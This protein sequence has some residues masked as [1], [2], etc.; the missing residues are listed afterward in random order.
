V[1]AVAGPRAPRLSSSARRKLVHGGFTALAL[2]YVAILVLAPLGG[3]VWQ[4]L[5]PG[6]SLVRATLTSPDVIHAYKL[7]A[8][9]TVITLVITTVFGIVVAL[10]VARDRFPGR[11]IV[12][13]MVDLPIAVSPVI[14]G[15]MAVLL[16]GRGGWFTSFF[17][18]RGIRILYAVPSMAIV[19]IFICIP[20]VIREVVPV[21]HELGT[22]EEEAARTLGAS[23]FQTFF[24]V[25]LKN[26]RWALA[27]GIALSTARSIGEIGAVAIVSGGITGQTETATLYILRQFDQYGDAQG[28]IVAV[29]LALVS[30]VLLI[31]IETFK[32]RQQKVRET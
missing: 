20:F 26:I 32:R 9:I 1:S 28:Y 10:V 25:T 22:A 7:T 15:V 19:T 14:V 3:I 29:T 18:A 12:S 11:S 23:S 16:F 8:I 27:Y 21:L 17:D 30:I 5:K 2:V 6:W 13:A 24:R 31:A 4:A